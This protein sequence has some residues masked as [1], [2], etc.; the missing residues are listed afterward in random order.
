MNIYVYEKFKSY[1]PDAVSLVDAFD[2]HDLS[3]NSALG[4]YDG[5]VY[6]RLFKCTE[7]DPMN[8]QEVMNKGRKISIHRLKVKQR[9][10]YMKSQVCKK[11]KTKVRIDG[12]L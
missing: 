4:C 10:K 1:R 12:R 5:H 6:E 2:F 7:I 9:V 8:Q 3:L 11:K